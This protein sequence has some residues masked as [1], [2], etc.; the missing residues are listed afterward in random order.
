[1]SIVGPQKK[2]DDKYK[3]DINLFTEDKVA[4]VIYYIVFYEGMTQQMRDQALKLGQDK[5]LSDNNTKGRYE[6][7]DQ[8]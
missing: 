4:C 6:D 5:T 3:E 1:M 8:Q 7:A 2:R